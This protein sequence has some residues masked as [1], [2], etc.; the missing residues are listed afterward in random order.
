MYNFE[1]YI[2]LFKLEDFKSLLLKH[3]LYIIVEK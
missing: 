2:A 1:K 3:N